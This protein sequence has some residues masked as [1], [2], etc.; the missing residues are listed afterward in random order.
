MDEDPRALEMSQELVAQ[1]GSVRGAF[2]QAR[3][4][5]H[6]KTWCVFQ[7]NDAQNGLQGREMIVGDPGF[8]I[9]G[10]G[11]KGGF[12]NIGETH[13]AYIGDQL[14]LQQQFQRPGRLSGLG[15][16]GCLHGGGGIVHVAVST[17]PSS[18]DH[19]SAHVSGH[20]HDDLSGIGFPDHCALRHLDLISLPFAGHSLFCRL[21]RAGRHT[22]AHV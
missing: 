10:H 11:Q 15:V 20:V 12:A 8:G 2:D 16:L 5:G 7:I 3:D 18:E 14:E 22:C 9:A 6:D 17:T 19:I 21:P 1:S 13:Q 4:I